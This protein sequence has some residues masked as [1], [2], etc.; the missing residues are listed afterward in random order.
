MIQRS[1][2][3]RNS[4]GAAL[5]LMLAGCA[6][7]EQMAYEVQIVTPRSD[8]Q[9]VNV[10]RD[11]VKVT[12]D[13][14]SGREL[15]SV[16]V[17]RGQNFSLSVKNLPP[18]A[19]SQTSLRVRAFDAEG[20]IV[21]TG[22]TPPLEF[23]RT[24]PLLM[25]P[26]AILV[27]KPG[28]FGRG[29]KLFRP[30]RKHVAVKVQTVTKITGISSDSRVAL[31]IFGTGEERP[32]GGA[33]PVEADSDS[34][35]AYDVFS[36][37][38][39][40]FGRT[41][42][43]EG[44]GGTVTHPRTDA[45]AITLDDGRVLLFGGTARSTM[46]GGAPTVLAQLDVFRAIRQNLTKFV[47][48]SAAAFDMPGTGVARALPTLGLLGADIFAFGGSDGIAALNTV[49]K[50]VPP[51]AANKVPTATLLTTPMLAHRVGHSATLL[52][53]P[54]VLLFGGSGPN[55]PIAELMLPGILGDSLAAPTFTLPLGTPGARRRDHI[56]IRL[57]GSDP[58][59]LILGGVDA[60]G[61]PVGD[62]V[63]YNARTRVLEPADLRLRIPRT[64]AAIFSVND[65]LVVAA[66][67]DATGA[68][69]NSAEI[70]SLRTLAPVREQPCAARAFAR[71]TDLGNGSVVI[72]G[73][74]AETSGQTASSD[75]VE[76]YQSGL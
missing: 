2:L 20:R 31:P 59:V 69:V 28:T 4:L 72:L 7:S 45:G 25:V 44:P 74:E 53:G 47:L 21:A 54:Q 58:R 11:A 19:S 63:L 62:A 68:Y 48:D 16:N 33:S 17:V 76:V 64:G 49:V 56:V 34:V 12:L 38:V 23:V 6:G 29:G 61:A 9:A 14:T 42:L 67:R 24:S 55:E 52:T 75:I 13:L 30:L 1:H 32:A 60:D 39:L 71:S 40:A 8:G 41:G 51:S 57:P 27:Q 43:T 37:D 22:E 66:G 35:Y 18:N 15:D 10:F 5:G 3:L 36:H 65:D 50:I 73:G 26:L 70:F 46:A